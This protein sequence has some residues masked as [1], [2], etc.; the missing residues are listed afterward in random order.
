MQRDQHDLWGGLGLAALGLA[1]A[2]HALTAFE[3]GTLRAMGPGFFPAVLGGLLAVLG[4]MIAVPAWARAGE[5]RPFHLPEAVAVLAAV[6]LFGA[7]LSRLGLVVTTALAVLLA[8]W[9]A[10]RP[11]AGWR[12]ALAGI[13]TALTWLV[14]GVGL[15]MTIPLW[16]AGLR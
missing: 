3:F 2:G 14:F 4:V 7:G 11:G 1:V 9:P 10:P 13:V 15:Q 16:P 12:L 8:S 5:A 6:V